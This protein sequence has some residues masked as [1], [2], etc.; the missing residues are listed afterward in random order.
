MHADIM[1][2]IPEERYKLL[3]GY[4]DI[5]KCRSDEYLFQDENGKAYRSS[6]YQKKMIAFCK[7]C[8]IEAAGY[9]FKSHDFRHTLATRLYNHGASVQVIRDFLGHKSDEMTKQYIDFIPRQ[10]EEKSKSLFK[11]KQKLVKNHDRSVIS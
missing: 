9:E 1:V 2:P 7:S 8:E 10:I 11:E 3:K 6:T 5:K 4:I